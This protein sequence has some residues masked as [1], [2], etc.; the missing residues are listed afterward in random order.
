MVLDNLAD[1]GV[2]GMVQADVVHDATSG[3]ARRLWCF[4]AEFPSAGRGG[5][6]ICFLGHVCIWVLV[7]GG[8][9]FVC[10]PTGVIDASVISSFSSAVRL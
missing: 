1:D 8:R 5:G 6:V 9:R 3:V 7:L 10:M 2:E 4:L